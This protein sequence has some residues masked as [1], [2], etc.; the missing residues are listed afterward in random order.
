MTK[1]VQK[2]HAYADAF[3]I[4]IL[5]IFQKKGKLTMKIKPPNTSLTNP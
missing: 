3:M 2:T 1:I 5:K 4:I